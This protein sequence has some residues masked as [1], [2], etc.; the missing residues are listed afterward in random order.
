MDSFTSVLVNRV[1]SIDEQIYLAL[2]TSGKVY[3]IFRPKYV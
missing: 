1:A 2:F 3:E